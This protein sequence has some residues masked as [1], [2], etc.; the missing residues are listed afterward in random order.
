MNVFLS[1]M[2]KVLQN[3]TYLSLGEQHKVIIEQVEPPT[4]QV[5]SLQTESN[6]I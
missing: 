1:E 3:Y 5:N 2:W 6:K 4:S